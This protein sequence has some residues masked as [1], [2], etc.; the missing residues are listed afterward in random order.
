MKVSEYFSE[1]GAAAREASRIISAAGTDQKNLALIE[2][3]NSLDGA[4]AEILAANK[5]DMDA[6]AAKGLDSALMD[7]LELNDNRIDAM[8][9]GLNQVAA[10]ADP[11]GEITDLSFRPSGIQVGKMRVPLGVIGIIYESRPNVTID[12][13]ALCLKSGN[14]SVLRGGSESINS[15]RAIASCIKQGLLAAGLPESVVSVIDS[16]DRDIVGLMITS[17]EVIDVIVPRGGK[18]LIARISDNARVPVI[19]H[20]E[21]NCHLY[22]HVDADLEKALSLCVNAKTHRYGVC[23][24]MESLLIHE[25]VAADFLP[26]LAQAYLD[27]SVE[28]RGCEKTLALLAGISSELIGP[29][30]ESDWSEEYLGP[31]ISI[32]VVDSIG[33]AISHINQYG[34]GHTDGII[35]QDYSFARQFMREVDSS[36]VVV[37]ASTRF[38]DG[39]EYGLGAEIG[40]STDKIHVRGPVGLEGLTSQKWVVLGEGHIRS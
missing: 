21:G 27:K 32:R 35:S 24:A 16:T 22:V 36:S 19:K 29:A 31:V 6:G 26:V 11:V 5:L 17:P 14:A 34:S 3:G 23:N 20:L 33:E 25:Q 1:V 9:E 2:I 39:F 4:R 18:S 13:A 7:R 38:A 40:I 15:N 28:I 10:L 37:N 8:I 12:A 30:S